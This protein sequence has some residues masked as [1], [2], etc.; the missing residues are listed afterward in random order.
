MHPENEDFGAGCLPIAQSS[1]YP[2][3][4]FLS[5]GLRKDGTVEIEDSL[6]AEK[7]CRQHGLAL[8]ITLERRDEKGP[9]PL[10]PGHKITI[11]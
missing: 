3:V 6:A 4:T 7:W 10:V 2:Y 1:P 11:S 9:H 8:A 5:L